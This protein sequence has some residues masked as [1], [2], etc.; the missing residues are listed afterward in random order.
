MCHKVMDCIKPTQPRSG[1]G[2]SFNA[3]A[4]VYDALATLTFGRRLWRAQARWLP[5][6]PPGT[7]V[8]WLGGAPAGCCPPCLTTSDRAVG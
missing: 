5:F 7:H 4:P 1:G 6:V 8:L 2:P 3:L